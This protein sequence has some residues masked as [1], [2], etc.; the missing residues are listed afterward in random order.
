VIYANGGILLNQEHNHDDFR[1]KREVISVPI[2]LAKSTKGKYFVGQSETLFVGN[3]SIAWAGLFNPCGSGKALHVNVMTISNFSDS[4]L[5]AEIWL[6]PKLM[7]NGILS[8]HVS[9]A[10]TDL[11]PKP[12]SCIELRYMPS[13]EEEPQGGVNIFDRIVPP[14]GTLVCEEDGKFII[15]ECGN[16]TIFLKSSQAELSKAIVAFGW[17]NEP[18][19]KTDG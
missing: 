5:T 13:D 10:N 15:P 14:K 2:S 1:K 6:N 3:S 18:K 16:Y 17:W 12:K 9:P 11:K 8:D 4:D 19:T 7:K